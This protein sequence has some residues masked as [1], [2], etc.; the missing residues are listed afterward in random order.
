MRSSQQRIDWH[1]ELGGV[2]GDPDADE[3]SVGG[4][5]VHAIG[6]DLAELLVLEVV[7]VHALRIAFGTIIGSA[8][9]EVA[10]QFLLLGVDGDDGLLLGLRRNDFRVD[11]FELGVAV[12]MSRAFIRLA[13]RLA[14]E[15]EFHQFRAHRVGTDRMP[16]LRQGRGKLLHA[17]RH[18]DQRSHGIAQRRRLNQALE[19]GDQ[20]RIVLANRAAT[21]TSTANLPLRQRLCIEI[22]LAAIDRRAGELGDFRDHNQ[23]AATSGSHLR[24]SE[25]APPPLVEPRAHHVPSQPNGGLVDHATDL[26]Q[27]AQSEFE[28]A[29]RFVAAPESNQGVG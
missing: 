9:L 19:R 29:S 16:H 4:H 6:H 10:N 24:R 1:G 28:L 12:G 3:S 18:P 23:T 22:L 20:L 2:A 17:F 27:L 25:Q 26:T 5:I 14:R 13:V 8:I 15:P 7:H 21:A 11:V